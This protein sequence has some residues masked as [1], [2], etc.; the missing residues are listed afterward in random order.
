MAAPLAPRTANTS[1]SWHTLR[2]YMMVT[3]TVRADSD[4]TRRAEKHP[5]QRSLGCFSARRVK[6]ESA[7]TVEVTIMYGRKVCQLLLVLAV[8]GASG[9]A[10]AGHGGGG[11]Y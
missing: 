10:M 7:R 9:A 1:N 11:Y 6:S 2:P 5:G 3:S 4:L 8:L